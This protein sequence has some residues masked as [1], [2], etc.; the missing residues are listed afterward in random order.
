MNQVG[1]EGEIYIGPFSVQGVLGVEW[2]NSVRSTTTAFTTVPPAVGAPGAFIA[3]NTILGFDVHTRFFDKINF[4][5]YPLP[6]LKVFI[7]HRYLGGR[8]ALAL[9]GEYALPMPG[10]TRVSLFAEGRVG[11]SDF[12]GIWGGVKVYFGQKDKSLIR[13]HREDDPIEWTPEGLGT[14]TNSSTGTG[15]TTSSIPI[16]PLSPP[17]PPPPPPES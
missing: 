8:H 4:A 15:T 17:P 5:Y 1:A 16:A 9:G 6:D 3:A 12:H 2:G 11:E 14:L 13:R 7:G 10:A